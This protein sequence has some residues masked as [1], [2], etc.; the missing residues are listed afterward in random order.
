PVH[1][2]PRAAGPLSVLA[3]SPSGKRLVCGGWND[4]VVHLDHGERKFVLPKTGRARS[5]AFA[6]NGKLFAM[7]S[8]YG[9]PWL[10]KVDGDKFTAGKEPHFGYPVFAQVSQ[11]T[12]SADSQWMAF[13]GERDIAVRELASGKTLHSIPLRDPLLALVL[14]PDKK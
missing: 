6:P 4:L 12:F 13:G 10:W 9:E 1:V 14:A 8:S 7:A 11:V 5:I 2:F 3:Y